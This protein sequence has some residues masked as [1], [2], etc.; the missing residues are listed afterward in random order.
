MSCVISQ[1]NI[2]NCISSAENQPIVIESQGEKKPISFAFLKKRLENQWEA[3]QYVMHL[4]YG[5]NANRNQPE[6]V[7]F[8]QKGTCSSKH[9]LLKM[10]AREQGWDTWS[11]YTGIYEM[12]EDNTPGVGEVLEMNGMG[13]IPEAHCYLKINGKPLDLTHSEA[14][15]AKLARFFLVEL[16]IEAKQVGGFKQEWH[17]DWL[18]QWCISEELDLEAVWKIREACI[19]ALS[20]LEK[21]K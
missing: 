14:D 13:F 8:E 1:K 10:L 18:Q 3:L 15:F 4:P 7:L 21:N 20:V 11:L 6:L 12:R 19:L 2:Q 9:G 5:R 17:R 16:E